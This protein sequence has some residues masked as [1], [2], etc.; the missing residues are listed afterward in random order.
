MTVIT[1]YYQCLCIQYSILYYS[2]T[3]R[4]LLHLRWHFD[5]STMYFT[6][7]YNKFSPK[8]SGKSTS[9]PLTTENGIA[10][11]VCYKLRNTHCR[12]I[13]SLSHGYATSTLQCHM[14]AICYMVLSNLPPPEKKQKKF[15]PSLT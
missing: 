6:T 15:F 12:Q 1:S 3:D 10:H 7:T 13:Q 5:A 4:V 11:F 2:F 9:L 14:C 8:S